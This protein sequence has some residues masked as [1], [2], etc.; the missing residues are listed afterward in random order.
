MR[1]D[2]DQTLRTLEGQEF[3]LEPDKVATLRAVCINALL[4]PLPDDQQAPSGS[5]YT[6]YS[7]AQRLYPGGVVELE[8]S[9]IDLIKKR[10]ERMYAPMVTGQ[11]WDMLE[12]RS[13][14][15]RR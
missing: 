15:D 3:H 2:L 14:G 6:L 10:V 9:E 8:A 1:I 5:G 4:T 13:P 11:T 12:Q 7:I